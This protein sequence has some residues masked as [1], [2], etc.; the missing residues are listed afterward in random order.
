[1]LQVIIQTELTMSS[2]NAPLLYL[3]FR[4]KLNSVPIDKEILT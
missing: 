4:K 3:L 1:M 2:V